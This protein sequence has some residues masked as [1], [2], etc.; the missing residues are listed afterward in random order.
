M[1]FDHPLPIAWCRHRFDPFDCLGGVRVA[2]LCEER[3]GEVNVDRRQEPAIAG[4][5]HD[6][7]GVEQRT[8]GRGW[9]AGEGLGERVEMGQV[10]GPLAHVQ[11]GEGRP[12]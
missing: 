12:G 4:F 6:R 5:G 3:V 10:R 8:L 1:S 11:L 7:L 2:A 9:I